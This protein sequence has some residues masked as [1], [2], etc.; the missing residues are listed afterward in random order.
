MHG[1]SPFAFSHGRAAAFFTCWFSVSYWFVPPLL[2]NSVIV[3]RYL[4]CLASLLSRSYGCSPRFRFPYHRRYIVVASC[5]LLPLSDVRFSMILEPA[6]LCLRLCQESP[7]SSL[8]PLSACLLI[9]ISCISLWFGVNLLSLY[10]S[11]QAVPPVP[12]FCASRWRPSAMATHD[13]PFSSVVVRSQPPSCAF[14]C[15]VHSVIISCGSCI[16]RRS[17][18]CP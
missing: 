2:C 7:V 14:T 18:T 4:A 3:L 5:H 1:K 9:L 13:V 12:S 11:L 8:I 17:L 6:S 10:L 15:C 16:L